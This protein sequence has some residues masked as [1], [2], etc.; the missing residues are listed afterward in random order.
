MITLKQVELRLSKIYG[1]DFEKLKKKDI[2]SLER[3]AIKLE[4]CKKYL[5][6]NP[7]E[8]FIVSEKDRLGRLVNAL[9]DGYS[10]WFNATPEARSVKNPET[11][12]RKD[13]GITDMK[14]QLKML[15]FLL[16]GTIAS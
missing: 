1:T 10:N 16:A 4:T 8:S 14:R 12:F 9:E 11:K 5:E 2:K 15:G 7:S 3:E 13:T 6:F